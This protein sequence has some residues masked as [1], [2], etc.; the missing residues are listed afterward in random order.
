LSGEKALTA[1][2]LVFAYLLSLQS[3]TLCMLDE[4]AIDDAK[5]GVTPGW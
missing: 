2:V 5:S 3:S 4:D 1:L